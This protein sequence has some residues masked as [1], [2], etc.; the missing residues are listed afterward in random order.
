MTIKI[1]RNFHIIH[2]TGDL[3]ALDAWYY[4]IFSVQRFMPDSYMP[5]EKRDASLVV[6]GD[7]CVEPLAPAFHVE[8]W[9]RMPLGRFYK[10]F[11][12]RYHSLAWYV[13][14]GWDDLYHRFQEAGIRLYGTGGVKQEGDKPQGV[15]F[16]HPR[17]TFTQ[18]EF[19][20]T[21]DPTTGRFLRDPRFQPG[22]SAA[23]WTDNHPLHIEQASHA[24]IAV[25]DANA[26]SSVYT[27]LL[28]ATL[29]H[30]GENPATLTKS[31]YVLVGDLVVEFAQPIDE[32]SLYA[33][34]MAQHGESLIAL[35]YRVRDLGDA[36]E[37]LSRKDVAFLVDDGTTLMSDPASTQGCL[38]GFTTERI[39]GD[40]RPD[41][42]EPA[43]LG[44]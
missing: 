12:N 31:S 27:D 22:W 44:T 29:V 17:D 11:G 25:R 18:L 1:G 33:A 39:P 6:L 20:P 15:V 3:K 32:A 40:P 41:W 34:D 14:D 37:Y 19:I 2:M 26:A 36:R 38:M 9:D 10:Q 16:T 35:T 30:E 43:T 24:T 5:Q 8:G 42:S 7:L 28:D 23:W 21:P 13:D 4:D